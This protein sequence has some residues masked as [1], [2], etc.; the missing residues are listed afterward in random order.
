MARP[1]KSIAQRTGHATNEERTRRT[2]TEQAL[3][4]G[5]DKLTPPDYLT[6]RQKEIFV[7]IVEELLPLNILGNTDIFILR[8]LS[9]SLDRLETIERD[10][11][12]R[13]EEGLRNRALLRARRVYIDT[14]EESRKAL[15]IPSISDKMTERRTV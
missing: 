11:N 12:E 7:N 15:L 1:P 10:I 13:G 2:Q 8:E 3:R 5:T 9:I 4:G 6:D 14:V